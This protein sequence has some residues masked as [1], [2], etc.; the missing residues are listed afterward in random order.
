MKIVIL[1]KPY[2][3]L[4]QFRKDEAHMTVSDFVDDP[5]LRIAG[6]LDM[7]SEGLVFLTDHG[8]LNQFITNPANKIYGTY[9]PEETFEALREFVVSI[10]GPLTTP[11]GGGIRS[12]NV[13]LRQE[14]DLYVCVRPV[15]WFQGVPSP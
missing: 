9:M 10:K 13:A 7:D 8:G 2:D 1:N 6:R 15:R 12:L 14:L 4:S 5:T 3:V 11:V